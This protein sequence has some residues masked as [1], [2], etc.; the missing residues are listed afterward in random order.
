ML[1]LR[2]TQHC[3]DLSKQK[4]LC[5][6]FQC[7]TST[8]QNSRDQHQWG[9]VLWSFTLVKRGPSLY[10]IKKIVKTISFFAQSDPS[11]FHTFRPNLITMGHGQQM[12]LKLCLDK[13]IREC[14][15]RRQSQWSLNFRKFPAGLS[16]LK[17]DSFLCVGGSEQADQ[18]VKADSCVHGQVN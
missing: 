17:H 2:Q 8:H 5:K 9:L 6:K 12:S 14:S 15:H 4:R 7:L 16:N 3:I 11:S 18:K 1:C 13:N 10:K